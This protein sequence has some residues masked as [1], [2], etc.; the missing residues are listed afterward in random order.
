MAPQLSGLWIGLCKRLS[1][2][3]AINVGLVDYGAGNMQSLANALEH[4]GA[5]VSRIRPGSPLTGITHVVLP[6]VGAFGYCAD[7]LQASGLISV[8]TEWAVTNRRPLLGICVGMQLLF[9]GSE[10]SPDARG[11]GWLE[12]RIRRLTSHQPDLRIPHVGWNDI[13]F[14]SAWGAF[15]AGASADFYFD[16]SFAYLDAAPRDV[17]ALCVHSQPFCAAVRRGN[18]IGAQFHPEKSQTAGQQFLRAFLRLQPC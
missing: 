8:L 10:E 5:E 2:L 14:D 7:R 11:L 4:V 6:G 9:T 13:R 16:H 12:G 17:L 3:P 18:I 1:A 15:A